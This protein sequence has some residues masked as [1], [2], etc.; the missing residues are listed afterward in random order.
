VGRA[1]AAAAQGRFKSIDN[2]KELQRLSRAIIER[3]A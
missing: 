2:D 3:L 1:A